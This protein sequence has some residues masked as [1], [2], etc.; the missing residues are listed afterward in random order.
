[1]SFPDV[2]PSN[3]HY[4]CKDQAITDTAVLSTVLDLGEI[5]D[6]GKQAIPHFINIHVATAFTEDSSGEY[7]QIDLVHKADTDPD[8][9]NVK[10]TLLPKTAVSSGSA[11]LSKGMIV[12]VPLPHGLENHIA[13]SLV[14]TSTLAAGKI[15]A[16]L[17]AG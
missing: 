2:G 14:N 13:L 12:K 16:F 3:A 11:L 8:S 15:T 7:L 17:T 9:S 10:M 5:T 1:M 4:F 6:I